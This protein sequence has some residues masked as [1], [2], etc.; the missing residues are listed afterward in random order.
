MLGCK[1]KEME[2]FISWAQLIAA[3][4]LIAITYAT[5]KNPQA[6]V[7]ALIRYVQ[8]NAA[9]LGIE[10]NKIGLRQCSERVIS[11]DRGRYWLFKMC[12]PLL[13]IHA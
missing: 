4:G 6:D 2:S 7:N 11:S 9:I 8:R 5:D 12:C 10:E 13:R 3:S 1:Q